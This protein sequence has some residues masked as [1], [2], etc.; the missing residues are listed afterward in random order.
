ME[1]AKLRLWLSL[2]VD[3]EDIKQI[4]PLPNLDYKIVTGNSLLGVEKNLFNVELFN[5]LENLKP[6]YFNETNAKKKQG[7]KQSIDQLIRQLTNDN[8]TFDFEVYF[9]E[10]FHEKGGFDVAI[11][12]PP[13][14]AYY[15]R[16]SK[17]IEPEYKKRLKELYG[18]ETG[19]SQ[20]SFL[21]FIVQGL[22]VSRK[23]GCLCYIVPDT[24][25]IN[26]RYRTIRRRLVSDATLISVLQATFPTFEQYV[27]SCIPIIKNERSVGYSCTVFIADSIRQL[28]AKLFSRAFVV[29]Q[30]DFL[31]DPDCRLLPKISILKRL[32]PT[33]TLA[34]ICR[35][36]DGINPGMSA[37]GLRPRL[38]LDSK[39]GTNPKKLIEG[40]NITRY[41]VCW[42]GR[43]VNYDPLLLTRE[44]KRGGASL[45][46]ET[47]FAQKQKLVSRQTANRLV[48]AL[49]D[50]QF[51]TTNSVHNTFITTSE[52]YSL[53][54]ILGILNSKFMGYIYCTLSGETRDIF[55]QVHIS[56]LKKLP[57]RVVDFENPTERQKHDEIVS[58]VN[59]MIELNLCLDS[60]VSQTPNNELS[61]RIQEIDN[62]IDRE[63]YELYDLNA[64]AIELIENYWK[65]CTNDE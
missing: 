12:N 37:L 59:Q 14:I 31:R 34:R 48:F 29:Q 49:D 55:P 9:S 39:H 4:Q 15:S 63:V 19:G 57:I 56:M 11:A 62:R 45:R 2:V 21:H 17:K 60:S 1:I 65:E 38:F 3:E 58:L 64:E 22:R 32:P 23:G 54:F 46:D 36:K 26:E 28:E 16:A 20:N 40:K 52:P 51:Y 5:E 18:K 47:I 53:K 24:F 25:M 30:E 43:W 44:A 10:V 13:Y 42:T 33:I 50:K 61:D 6:L 8:E 41:R 35:I 7:Y 27:R